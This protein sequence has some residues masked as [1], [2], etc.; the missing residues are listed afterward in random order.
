M[1]S[2]GGNNMNSRIYAVRIIAAAITIYMPQI[3]S[4]NGDMVTGRSAIS[5]S[6]SAEESPVFGAAWF[7]SYALTDRESRTVVLSDVKIMGARFPSLEGENLDRFGDLVRR[8][9]EEW[10]FLITL[11]DMNAML[12]YVDKQN[13]AVEGMK[14]DPPIRRRYMSRARLPFSSSLTA[15]RRNR[16]SRIP[17]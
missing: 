12:E 7:E 4:L 1:A 14:N 9:I 15:S 17:A 3:E 11:D 13:I 8:E 16:I 10:E 5:V 6:V 2:Q